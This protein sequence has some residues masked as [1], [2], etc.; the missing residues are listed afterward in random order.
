MTKYIFIV[1]T[2]IF[3]F[4]YA[5]IANIYALHINGLNTTQDEAMA[6]LRELKSVSKVNSNMVIF[7]VVYNP[8]RAGSEWEWVASLKGFWDL[9]W[10]KWYEGNKLPSLD[11][12]TQQAMKAQGVDYPVGSDQ[13][14]QFQSTLIGQF[15]KLLN[16]EDGKN[17]GTVIDEFH[18]IVPAQY[19][20][21]LSLISSNG[22]IDYSKSTTHI[23]LLP[24]SQGNIYANNLYN[25]LTQTESFS[26]QNIG[27]FGFASPAQSEMGNNLEF[28]GFP[29]NYITST[30]DGV[31]ASARL[32]FGDSNVLPTNITIPKTESD[33][34]GHSLIQVYLSDKETSVKYNKY[35]DALLT[36]FY[37][38]TTLLYGDIPVLIYS[39]MMVGF[40][41]INQMATFNNAVLVKD[42]ILDTS[43][44]NIHYFLPQEF[45]NT[46]PY[47]KIILDL[48]PNK[49]NTIELYNKSKYALSPYAGRYNFFYGGATSDNYYN[50]ICGEY[51]TG[52]ECT[53]YKLTGQSM[54]PYYSYDSSH[55][56]DWRAQMPELFD[57]TYPEYMKIGSYTITH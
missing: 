4:S 54:L 2:F 37:T 36:V 25:Y 21:V 32:F 6:N 43:N 29:D 12:F 11:E 40:T 28:Q 5:Q 8:T 50:P 17:M 41:T 7:N 30:N 55:E 34:S 57:S 47:A 22:Q 24:H 19:A 16:D 46:N 39:P 31:I 45:T 56:A 48:V 26:Y 10:Q 13:Y 35:L 33:T 9:M 18:N 14:K 15:Q 1:L 53:L 51:D 38:D 44:P 20:S 52:Y 3:K 49:S 23:L 42:D 27:I